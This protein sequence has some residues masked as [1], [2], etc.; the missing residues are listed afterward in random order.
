MELA[1]EWCGSYIPHRLLSYQ[2]KM[3]ELYPTYFKIM[4]DYYWLDEDM[5]K[6]LAIMSYEFNL[7]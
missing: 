2:F 1:T 6:R 7:A 5:Y 3:S 4:S